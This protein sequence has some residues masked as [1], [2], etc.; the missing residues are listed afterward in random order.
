MMLLVIAVGARIIRGPPLTRSQ[1]R[2][3]HYLLEIKLGYDLSIE[4]QIVIA[5]GTLLSISHAIAATATK[6][7]ETGALRGVRWLRVDD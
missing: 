6:E 5:R 2:G 7:L 3:C 1:K 4:W